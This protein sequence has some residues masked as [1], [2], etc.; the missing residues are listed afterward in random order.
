LTAALILIRFA[1]FASVMLLFGAS[2]FLAALAPPALRTALARPLRRLM[3]GAA[4]VAAASAVLWLLIEGAEM[5]GDWS[6]AID[7]SVVS[8]VLYDTAFGHVWQARLV[9]ALALIVAALWRPFLAPTVTAVLAGLLLASLGLVGHA[10]MREGAPGLIG[11]ANQALHL[12]AGGFWLGALAPL[13]YCLGRLRE[14]ALKQDA[15]VA[16]R[17][18]SGFGHVAVAIVLATGVVNTFT[19]LGRWPTGFSSP[20]QASL[21]MKI[22]TV[23]AMVLLAL[24]NRYRLVPRLAATPGPVLRAL[25]RNTLIELILGGAVLA[26]VSAFATFEPA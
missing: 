15:A 8:S 2:V 26:L 4:L 21:A 22:A 20:Y 25:S 7:P 6:D 19:I 5:G 9:L 23:A 16:L 14:P 17:R 10:A 24:F 12:L 13:V 1:H 11:R 3:I 18:F